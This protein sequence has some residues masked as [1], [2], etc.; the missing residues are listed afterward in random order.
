MEVRKEDMEVQEET[1]IGYTLVVGPSHLY[2]LKW[3]HWT[4]NTNEFISQILLLYIH[5]GDFFLSSHVKI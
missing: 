4:N 1:V 2:L 5:P 3:V